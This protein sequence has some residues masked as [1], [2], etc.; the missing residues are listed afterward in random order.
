[1]AL[2]HVV[3]DIVKRRKLLKKNDYSFVETKDDIKMLVMYGKLFPLY[4]M[5]LRFNGEE[6]EK[7]IIYVP[8]AIIDLK[9]RADDMIEDL[10][11]K[12]QLTGYSCNLDYKGK[13]LVPSS[14]IVIGKKDKKEIFTEK[15]NIW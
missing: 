2:I 3:K 15:I 10:I 6:S 9:N 13:S 7:N 1:M 14:L 12:G 4:L 8:K 11:K 5:P